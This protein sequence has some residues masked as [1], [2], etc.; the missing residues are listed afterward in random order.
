M[1]AYEFAGEQMDCPN[2]PLASDGV[3]GH[4]FLFQ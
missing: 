1:I 3:Q 4:L 2:A